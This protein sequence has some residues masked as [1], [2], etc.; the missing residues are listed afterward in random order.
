MMRGDFRNRRGLT[1]VE[2][3]IALLIL[4]IAIVI[5]MRTF[6]TV[7]TV[8]RDSRLVNQAAAYAAAKLS[9]FSAYP[10]DRLSTGSDQVVSPTGTSFQRTWVVTPSAQSSK[11][12]ITVAWTFGGRGDSIKLGTIL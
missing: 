4:A 11:V 10:R 6:A 7:G 3:P 12:E 8:Q 9:E 1:L 5:G 2:I